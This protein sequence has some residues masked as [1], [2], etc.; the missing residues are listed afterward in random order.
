MIELLLPLKMARI[1]LQI[2]IFF[3]LSLTHSLNSI[4]MKT[5][6]KKAYS[7][8]ALDLLTQYSKTY[9]LARNF[10][11]LDREVKL[12]KK[13]LILQNVPIFLDLTP[14]FFVRSSKR[15]LSR[16]VFAR[17]LLKGILWSKC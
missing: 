1:N 8:L 16:S 14:I 4:C 7:T 17:V 6:N 2:F 12:H 5:W 9:T 10:M 15:M 13:K 3:Y 11:S